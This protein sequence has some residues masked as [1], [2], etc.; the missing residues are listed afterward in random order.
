MVVSVTLLA[1]VVVDGG[2][3]SISSLITTGLW[4]VSMCCFIP[5]FVRWPNSLPRLTSLL[6][7][8]HGAVWPPKC[9]QILEGWLL[10]LFGEDFSVSSSAADAIATCLFLVVAWPVHS[11]V[12]LCFCD[13]T[14]GGFMSGIVKE[15]TWLT[16][17]LVGLMFI[18]II[19]VTPQLFPLPSYQL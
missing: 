2:D 6:H 5:E 13:K 1:L 14:G 18:V 3:T 8:L 16:V 10:P 7:S 17:V 11:A 15:V 12:L 9:S 4:W 19:H